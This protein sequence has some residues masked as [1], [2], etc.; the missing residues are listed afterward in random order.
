MALSE[1]LM[2]YRNDLPANDV[3]LPG[4][5]HLMIVGEQRNVRYASAST[6]AGKGLHLRA[7]K[8]SCNRISLPGRNGNTVAEPASG[9]DDSSKMRLASCLAV[10]DL[11]A[12]G[13][14]HGRH[15]L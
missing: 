14:S 6:V 7:V 11:R 1:P 5:A 12:E 4:D 8:V 3:L 15:I 9:S 10:T 2:K 13:C